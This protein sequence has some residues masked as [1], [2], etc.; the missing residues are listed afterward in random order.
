MKIGVP[1]IIIIIFLL[2]V[3]L[4]HMLKFIGMII[5]LI[6]AFIGIRLLMQLPAR[7]YSLPDIWLF[8]ARGIIPL[9][10]TQ[11]ELEKENKAEAKKL[12]EKEIHRILNIKGT[13]TQVNTQIK[14]HG[15]IETIKYKTKKQEI[16]LKLLYTTDP[17]T[18]IAEEEST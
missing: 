15:I 1:H 7:L 6:L 17:Y 13:I 4:I 12:I 9:K 8:H 11:S 16:T 14:P 18:L 5:A 2:E 10:I 3:I